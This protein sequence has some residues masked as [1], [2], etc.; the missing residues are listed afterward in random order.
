[1]QIMMYTHI[2]IILVL[3]LHNIIFGKTLFVTENIGVV[4]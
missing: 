2:F 1:M 3:S 4:F